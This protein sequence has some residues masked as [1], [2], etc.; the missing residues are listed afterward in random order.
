M[1][2]DLNRHFPKCLLKDIQMV[3]RHMKI[4]STS[5]IIRETQMKT[6]IRITSHL[7]EW[8]R[9]KR[10]QNKCCHTPTVNNSLT[11]EARIQHGK[12]TDSSASGVGEAGKSHV[13]Q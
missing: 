9:S 11:K 3:N 12:K 4:C 6:T 5:L 7:S 10:I 1:A 8:L 2:E 13:N